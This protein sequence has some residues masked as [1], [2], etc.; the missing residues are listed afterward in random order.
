ME[1]YTSECIN[2]FKLWEQRILI[3][4]VRIGCQPD[5]IEKFI[6][7][8]ES[9]NFKYEI[10]SELSEPVYFAIRSLSLIRN[11]I[12]S[13][14][15]YLSPGLTPAGFTEMVLVNAFEAGL[16]AGMFLPGLDKEA[17][18]REYEGKSSKAASINASDERYKLLRDFKRK[19]AIVIKAEWERGSELNH[20][21]MSK[22]MANDYLDAQGKHS[23]ANLPGI[24]ETGNYLPAEK[25]LLEVAKAVALEMGRRDLVSGLKK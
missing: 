14:E 18:K 17:Y 8:Y 22:F 23:F 2:A 6:A 13:F 20:S 10:K 9:D 5:S 7:D 11:L 4:L 25:V 16:S 24:D 3:T 21:K 19:A 12:L 15:D 1:P